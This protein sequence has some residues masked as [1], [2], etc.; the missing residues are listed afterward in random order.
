M[1]KILQWCNQ[2]S[3]CDYDVVSDS[4]IVLWLQQKPDK[5]GL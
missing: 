5:S 3:L 4:Y 1:K 2:I